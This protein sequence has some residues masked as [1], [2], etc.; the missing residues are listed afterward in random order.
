[1]GFLLGDLRVQALKRN[2]RNL[3]TRMCFRFAPDPAPVLELLLEIS[4]L[5]FIYYLLFWRL[6]SA[7][8]AFIKTFG[9]PVRMF[10][11]RDVG[12]SVKTGERK[13]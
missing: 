5:L 2:P 4:Y 9:C 1:M 3:A 7:N 10:C 11:F 6:R 8:L 13:A 12:V